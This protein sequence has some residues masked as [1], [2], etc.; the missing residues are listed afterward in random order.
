MSKN[1]N[2]KNKQPMKRKSKKY[3]KIPREWRGSR[4]KQRLAE[5]YESWWICI[6]DQYEGGRTEEFRGWTK[7]MFRAYLALKGL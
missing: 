4:E 5:E 3:G 2:S 6:Y 7:G 1:W